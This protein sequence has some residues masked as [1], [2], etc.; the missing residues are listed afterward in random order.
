MGSA[1]TIVYE[2]DLL[3]WVFLKTVNIAVAPE[4]SDSVRLYAL[5]MLVRAKQ[6]KVDDLVRAVLSEHFERP[7]VAQQ[8]AWAG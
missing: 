3:A 2:S 6:I 4:T 5:D 8:V 1:M 7:E